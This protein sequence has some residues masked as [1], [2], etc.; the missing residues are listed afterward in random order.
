MTTTV[1]RVITGHDETG[2]AIVLMDGA[3]GNVKVRPGTGI[4]ATLLWVT[5]ETPSEET[6]DAIAVDSDEADIDGISE[7]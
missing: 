1:R 6:E 7:E 2:R 5:D 3:A 4:G